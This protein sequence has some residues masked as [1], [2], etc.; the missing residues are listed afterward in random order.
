LCSY[1][2]RLGTQPY[3]REKRVFGLSIEF[4]ILL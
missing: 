4:V 3:A 2:A 1:A